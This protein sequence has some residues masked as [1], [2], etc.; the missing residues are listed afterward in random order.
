MSQSQNVNRVHETG[1]FQAELSRLEDDGVAIESRQP[2]GPIPIPAEF[3]VAHRADDDYHVPDHVGDTVKIIQTA[4]GQ[5]TGQVGLAEAIPPAEATPALALESKPVEDRLQKL[6]AEYAANFEKS[7]IQ[8]VSLD[9]FNEFRD[10]VISTFKHLGVDV[11][12]HF[13][14]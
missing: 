13:N 11:R 3:R 7:D 6:L 1:F 10:Q 12:K 9:K 2:V 8:I 5:R 14:G 4:E